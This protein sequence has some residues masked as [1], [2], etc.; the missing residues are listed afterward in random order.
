MNKH[1]QPLALKELNL[2]RVHSEFLFL[3]IDH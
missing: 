2:E 1:E 3:I